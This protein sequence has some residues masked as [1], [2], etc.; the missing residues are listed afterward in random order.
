MYV[1]AVIWSLTR[2]WVTSNVTLVA[3][4]FIMKTSSSSSSSNYQIKL[5]DHEDMMQSKRNVTLWHS[6][7]TGT[8]TVTKWHVRPSI[9]VPIIIVKLPNQAIKVSM[10]PILLCLLKGWQP[11]RSW[12]Q[13]R[14]SS[15]PRRPTAT[16]ITPAAAAA[17]CS[18]S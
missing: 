13:P 9:K 18:A 12:I 5:P 14:T 8:V 3:T 2:A 16:H 4:F 1:H 11:H 7:L 10:M 6:A 15:Q 17:D